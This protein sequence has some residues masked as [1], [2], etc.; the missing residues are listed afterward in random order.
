MLLADAL[1]L[2]NLIS[3][4]KNKDVNKK[5]SSSDLGE[6]S[7]TSLSH[8]FYCDLSSLMLRATII[9]ALSIVEFILY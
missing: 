4:K 3:D 1:M 6:K 9:M 2:N 5:D 8:L 7:R